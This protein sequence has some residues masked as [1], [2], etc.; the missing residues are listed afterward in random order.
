MAAARLIANPG[1]YPTSV[2]L[3]LIPIIA[4]GAIETSAEQGGHIVVDSCSGTSG[5][6]RATGKGKEH[7]LY[8]EASGSFLA[9]GVGHHRHMPEIEQVIPTPLHV[10]GRISPIFPP[11][12]PFFARFH[13]LDEAVPTSPKPESRATKQCQGRPNT[14]LAV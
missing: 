4:A 8:A 10:L 5:A 1:C 13:R 11:F 6:G 7:L 2:Q 3:P 12:F 9:Y 14:V